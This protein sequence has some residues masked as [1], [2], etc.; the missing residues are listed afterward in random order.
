MYKGYK[1]NLLYDHDGFPLYLEKR[2]KI[3]KSNE[4][5]KIKNN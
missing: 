5:K 3:I 2:L 1:S 4:N